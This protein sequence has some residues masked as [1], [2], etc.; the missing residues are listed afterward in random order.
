MKTNS[1]TYVDLH[2][3]ST[4]SDG[5]MTPSEL[6]DYAIEKGLSA[7][8]LT[9]HD[10]I[11]GLSEAISYA[12][13][14]PIEV[15]PG[16]EISTEY[17]SRDI[18]ILGLYL[19]TEKREFRQALQAF[20]DSRTTRN[21]KLCKKLREIGMD[22]TYEAMLARFP[23][24]T[25]T[26]AHYARYLLEHGYVTS[27][28]E[29]FDRYLGD[30]TPYYIPREKVTPQQ[31]VELILSAGGI[32]ILA[33]PTLYHMSSARLEQLVEKL[34][35]AGLMG[36]EAIYST[37]TAGEQR[38][39]LQL[40]EKYQLLI[41]G[42]SDFHG[43]NKPNLD[44]GCG[45][46]NLKIPA[47]ILED[48]KR[49]RMR[50]VFS[51]LDGTLLNHDHIVSQRTRDAIHSMI[52]RG[53]KLIIS[54]GRPLNSI[55]EV[56]HQNGLEQPGMLVIS[57]NGALV[58]DCDSK[59]ALCEHRLCQEDVRLIFREASAMN[60]YCQTYTDTHILAMGSGE[61]LEFY[62]RKIH[63]PILL[64]NAADSLTD[65]LPNGSYKVLAIDLHDHARLEAFR[66]H[67]LSLYGDRLQ[68]VFSSDVLL[69][70]LPLQAGKGSGVRFV[71]DYFQV[72]LSHA[73]ACG[74]AENDLSMLEA[75][76]TGVAMKNA[77]PSVKEKA[78]LVTEED[79]DHDGL[80]PLFDS[81]P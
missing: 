20:Q 63:L 33:H 25:I 44:L 22:I 36:I 12:Q 13:G 29:A 54:S 76:G 26:R 1:D 65:A 74:D 11:D 28:S 9:D 75:A 8:A 38:Q 14:K 57:N 79:N 67:I 35:E 46:G 34:K 5:T 42:G 41:S 49:S 45:Y 31:A 70:L 10:T 48:L 47:V 3:H 39:I 32:P 19:N 68:A 37:Y 58:Y 78:A 62:T 73:Y 60:I 81:L 2:V 61:E 43:A 64:V 52:R 27:L 16:I 24:S 6:V 71:C 51:D 18:H 56:L 40:A 80:V 15:V 7:F 59:K 72:P 30:H 66:E 55:L 23:D 17:E 77:D 4:C 21:H 69:E 50:L 53:H